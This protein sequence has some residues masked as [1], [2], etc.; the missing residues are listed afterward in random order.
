MI[1]VRPE[2]EGDEGA[3]DA[4]LTEAFGG[5]REEP[6]LVVALRREAS[7]VLSRVAV[8]EGEVAGYVIVSPGKL[9]GDR[10][11]LPVAGVGPLGVLPKC[12]RQGLGSALM[13]DILQASAALGWQALFLLGNPDYYCRFGFELSAPHGIWSKYSDAHFQR[14]EIVAGSLDGVEGEFV[15][16]EAFE[17]GAG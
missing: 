1:A 10:A 14:K 15:Y 8:V 2:V 17:A 4:L 12:Q 3:I 11:T 6:E 13:Q 16:H 9:G 5:S 7:P